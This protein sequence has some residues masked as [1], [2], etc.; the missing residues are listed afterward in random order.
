MTPP[1][2]SRSVGPVCVAEN[3]LFT[4]VE[5]LVCRADDS[6]YSSSPSGAPTASLRSQFH[7]RYAT[8]LLTR[9]A[10]NGSLASQGFGTST[11]RSSTVFDS[12]PL[13]MSG[14]TFVTGLAGCSHEPLDDMPPGDNTIIPDPTDNPPIQ[15]GGD[16]GGLG[17]GILAS[18]ANSECHRPIDLD[19]ASDANSLIMTCSDREGTGNAILERINASTGS[20]DQLLL[21][22]TIGNDPNKPVHLTSAASS[23]GGIVHVGFTATGSDA[24]FR[25]GS[26]SLGLS[27]IFIAPEADPN[28]TSQVLYNPLQQ[29]AFGDVQPISLA[30]IQL[31]NPG[32]PNEAAQAGVDATVNSFSP[33]T[34]VS[35]VRVGNRLYT[36]ERNLVLNAT[37]G[38]IDM[39]PTTI[40]RW[41]VN[42]TN[43]HLTPTPIGDAQ[44]VNQVPG[45]STASNAFLISG[46]Y[47]ATA[48][49]GLGE[50]RIAA[51]IQG[52]PS[53]DA[54]A[55][56]SS[57]LRVYNLDMT[58]GLNAPGGVT[59]TS[60]ISLSDSTGT[61]RANSSS[62]LSIVN[63]RF[64]LVGSA[65]GSGRIAIVDLNR[66]APPPPAT[67]A[68]YVKVFEDGSDIANIVAN[69]NGQFAYVISDSGQIRTVTLSEGD[70]FGKVGDS[71][72]LSSVMSGTTI[73]AAFRA[74]SVIAAR[75]DGYSKAP[76]ANQ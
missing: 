52:L 6:Q 33:N 17:N 18:F 57:Q 59:T 75:P 16:N 36:I 29:V 12:N 47:N 35:M 8:Q 53:D 32:L 40:H 46:A 71:F 24:E 38:Q 1:I 11:P 26:R 60:T 14:W 4:P 44:S 28:I 69:P 13:A 19:P 23:G 22:D 37:N 74:N 49:A 25:G 43:G 68:R 9:A 56:E 41:D 27:G 54:D 73:P 55:E 67:R 15:T 42:G 66:D 39:A 70:N 63:N 50:D 51:V 61:F 21:P 10:S 45:S 58:A 48:I 76:I 34:A 72:T 31:S 2:S 3:P 20:V 5:D 7:S 62:Q 65:D 64:A 30:G